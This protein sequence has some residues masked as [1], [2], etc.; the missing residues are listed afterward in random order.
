M[1]KILIVDD[2]MFA[3]NMV[4][5]MIKQAGHQVI[6]A[7]DG[8]EGLAR[9]A[10]ERPDVVITDLLMPNL[11]GLSFLSAIREDDQSLPVVI[12][13]ANIQD[14]MRQKCLEAGATEFMHKPPK[15]EALIAVLK[16]VL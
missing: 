3:L 13:S 16:R 12:L 9:I 4:S 8:E 14:S 2:A 6:T 5:R 11:D 10:A 7:K 1:A 15:Q